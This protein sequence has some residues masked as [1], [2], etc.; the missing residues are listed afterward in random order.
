MISHKHKCI[1]I[2]I[3]SCAGT[4]IEKAIVG[5]D[6]F[7]KDWSTKHLTSHQ[8]KILYSKYWD[9]YF[10]FAFVRN[11]WP[12]T[13]SLAKNP[14]HGVYVDHSN[15]YIDFNRDI[16][17]PHYILRNH[18]QCNLNSNWLKQSQG[19][20]LF[21]PHQ[22]KDLYIKQP[23]KNSIYLNY[24][25]EDLDFIG[26]FENLQ[27]DWLFISEKIKIKKQLNKIEPTK[28]K[29]YTHYTEYYNDETREIVA[30]KYA[31]DIKQFGYKFGE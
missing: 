3:P 16:Q 2:H 21:C 5:F 11:P 12:R 8:A 9:D 7:K 27:E 30:Q 17:I 25:L 31:R 28:D 24:L 18:P 14:T 22:Q 20:E 15:K 4:S 29:N 6:W 19:F 26:R 1:F 23:I 10:K 13:I